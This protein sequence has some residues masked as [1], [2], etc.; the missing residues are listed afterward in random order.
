M[1]IRRTPHSSSYN[2]RDETMRK[3]IVH[4]CIGTM[5]A[6]L[7]LAT[8]PTI[9]LVGAQSPSATKTNILQK[10]NKSYTIKELA[11]QGIDLEQLYSELHTFY[12][13]LNMREQSSLS[14]RDFSTINLFSCRGLA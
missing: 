5:L 8:Y 11:E 1:H 7:L 13:T 4:Q 9:A 2:G 3:K 6:G 12:S 14:L 10:E